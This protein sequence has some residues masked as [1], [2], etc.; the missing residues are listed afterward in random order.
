MNLRAFF[1]LSAI[2]PLANLLPA[3]AQERDEERKK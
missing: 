3:F 2:T 1:S